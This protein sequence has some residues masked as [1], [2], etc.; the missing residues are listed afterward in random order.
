ME[1]ELS[2]RSAGLF[3][4][5]DAFARATQIRVLPE[6]VNDLANIMLRN[7][8]RWQDAE[9]FYRESIIRHGFTDA[10]ENLAVC[11]LTTAIYKES[12]EGWREAWQWYEW[13]KQHKFRKHQMVW[14]GEPLKGKRL[15]IQLEQGLGD[16]AW[17]LRFV[18]RAKEDGAHTVILAPP[19]TM[20]LCE[21]QPYVDEVYDERKKHEIPADYV[22]MLMSMPGYMLPDSM[23]QRDG[24][25]LQTCLPM[26]GGKKPRIGLAWAGSTDVGYQAW[27]NIQLGMLGAL[28]AIRPDVEFVS[29]QQGP[30]AGDAPEV[31]LQRE[32]IKGCLDLWDTARLMESLDLV[33]SVDTVIPHLA[34]G[35]GVETW[36]LARWTGDWMWGVEGHDPGWYHGVS[37]FRQP[38]FGAWM[39][40][41][42]A[43]MEK[44]E[45]WNPNEDGLP[46]GRRQ[47]I[48]RPSGG[49][50]AAHRDGA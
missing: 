31:E 33:I 21:A 12:P 43:I 25:Y 50:S 14:R 40:V 11:L 29:L 48:H 32:S 45:A 38:S 23:P 22:T 47:G 39:P 34:A 36:V 30:H 28:T 26:A 44:L 37:I 24:G 1:D 2:R 49:H 16:H 46:R 8:R 17:G 19:S 5:K 15:I 7:E 10:A 6:V 42:D 27:R 9:K 4:G 18:K 20:R 41:L 35:L 3:G 13:R